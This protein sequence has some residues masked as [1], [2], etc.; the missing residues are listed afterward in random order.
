MIETLATI[1]E[2]SEP[3]P[4][5]RQLTLEYNAEIS[6]A[7]GQ[8]AMLRAHGIPEPLLRRALA[9]YRV[10]GPSRL[11]FLFQVLGRGTQVLAALHPGDEVESLAP[12]GNAWPM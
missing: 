7:P 9:V 2:N 1:V 11:A 5:Y 12:L 6:A 8:F 3:V 10:P 4:G